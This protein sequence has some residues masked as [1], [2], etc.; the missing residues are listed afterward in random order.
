MKLNFLKGNVKV[1]C[2]EKKLMLGRAGRGAI[3]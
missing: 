1:R 2:E 3:E